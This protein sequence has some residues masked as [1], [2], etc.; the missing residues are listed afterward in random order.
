MLNKVVLSL[1]KLDLV[2]L[3]LVKLGTAKGLMLEN[4]QRESSQLF[5]ASPNMSLPPQDNPPQD[6]SGTVKDTNNPEY[7]HKTVF[8]ID[9]K[10]RAL[11]RVF[12][13]H[14]IKLQ[15]FTKGY[16]RCPLFA[17]PFIFM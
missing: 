1:F 12:K 15:V 8:S 16:V 6:R 11:A 5:P 7:N 14:S 2:R 10:S 17:V 3:G 4:H 13:R 9:R